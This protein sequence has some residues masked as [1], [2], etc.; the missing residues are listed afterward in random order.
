MRH[1]LGIL[2]ILAAFVTVL[3]LAD[4]TGSARVVDGYTPHSRDGKLGPIVVP[5]LQIPIV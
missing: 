3:A 5:Y 4:V 2:G 1:L